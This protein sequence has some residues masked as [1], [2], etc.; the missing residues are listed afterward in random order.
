M[1][2]GLRKVPLVG[3]VPAGRP[4]EAVEDA[5][6]M[7]GVDSGMFPEADMFA[8]RVKGES[9]TGAGIRD[10]DVALVRQTPEAADGDIVVAVVDGEATVKRFFGREGRVELRAENPEFGD[11]VVWPGADFRL[12]GVVAGIVRRTGRR[13]WGV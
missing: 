6:G 2:A 9:M 13:E 5:E 10:G 3:T 11:V 8:L 4:V 12:A 7:I 1:A